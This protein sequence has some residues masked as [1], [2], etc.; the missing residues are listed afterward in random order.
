[1]TYANADAL[2][3]TDWLADHLEA[4]DVR[5]V[6]ATW[7]LPTVE[8][9]ARAEYLEGHIPGAVH[10]D[11]DDIADTDS[12]LPHML[13][14]PEKFASRVFALGLGD[15]SRIVVYDAN[16]GFSAAARVWW[17]F[18]VFGHDDVAVLDG[19]L[20]KWRADGHPLEDREP[21]PT[22]RQF[23]ARFDHLLVRDLEQVKRNLENRRDQVVDARTA[24]RFAGVGEEPRPSRK[25]G[26]VPGSLNLPFAALMD[27]GD[28]FTLR[29]AAEIEAAFAGA[30]VD[31]GGKV[32]ATCGS[33]VTAAVLALGLYL[34]GNA[35]GAVYD[36]SWSEWGNRDDTPVEP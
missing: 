7:H 8:R 26:H 13:P 25:K 18:R 22:P 36:G 34:I 15:G 35:E 16:G 27:P 11:I 4:P 6:D 9:D 12:D 30:G 32:V 29:P 10:F 31:A 33:G 28:H 1:M 2:V 17:T 20:G 19:G 24:E 5:V 3:S 14:S 21:A 23:T